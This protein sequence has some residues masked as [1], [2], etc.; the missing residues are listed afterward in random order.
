MMVLVGVLVMVVLLV[1]VLMMVVI[2]V[3]VV[4][5]L[6]VVLMIQ[7]LDSVFPFSDVGLPLLS[8][9]MESGLERGGAGVR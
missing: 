8:H 4:V 7:Y 1:V 5:V 2:M 3:E 6:V 9:H